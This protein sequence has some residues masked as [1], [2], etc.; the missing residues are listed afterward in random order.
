MSALINEVLPQNYCRSLMSSGSKVLQTHHR[1]E[2]GNM[3]WLDP[4]CVILVPN[5][6]TCAYEADFLSSAFLRVFVSSGSCE[7]IDDQKILF[8]GSEV[9]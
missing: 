9:S 4:P 1:P 8:Q 6:V 3:S 7:I 5:S 2:L